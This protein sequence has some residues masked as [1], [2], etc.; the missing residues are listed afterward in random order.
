[1]VTI[2]ANAEARRPSLRSGGVGGGGG[3]LLLL[4]RANYLSG[5]VSSVFHPPSP[6][7]GASHHQHN[8]NT[9]FLF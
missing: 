2:C 4:R 6:W 9:R 3:G 7:P 8:E 5:K 1:M